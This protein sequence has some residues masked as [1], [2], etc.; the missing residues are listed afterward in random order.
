MGLSSYLSITNGS[1]SEFAEEMELS[2]YQIIQPLRNGVDDRRIANH[3]FNIEYI[4][5]EENNASYLPYGYE[6]V[7]RSNDNPAY[8]LAKTEA[9]FPFAYVEDRIT[10]RENFSKLNPVEKENFLTQGVVLENDQD[11][12]GR[13]IEKAT[14]EEIKERSEERR[15][16][17]ESKTRWQR[18]VD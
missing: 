14:N 8:I 4:L 6:V 15:V 11:V 13:E 17:K 3:F 18:T 5:T 2:S 9:D 16:G 12:E 1:L 10:T 7:H